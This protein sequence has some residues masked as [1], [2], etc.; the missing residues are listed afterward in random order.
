MEGTWLT[1][2]L[3][4]G[5]L[6]AWGSLREND[7]FLFRS[8]PQKDNVLQFW[9]LARAFMKSSQTGAS[10]CLQSRLQLFSV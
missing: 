3:T 2:H 4:R 1:M 9:I 8:M 7:Q 5:S 10:A 6:A